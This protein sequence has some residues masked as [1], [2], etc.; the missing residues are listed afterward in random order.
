MMSGSYL[1]SFHLQIR[2]KDEGYFLDLPDVH[3]VNIFQLARSVSQHLDC[4]QT[5]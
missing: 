4:D 3:Y 1:F 2:L 5:L